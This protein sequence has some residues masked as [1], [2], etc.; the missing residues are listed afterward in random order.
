MKKTSILSKMTSA[1]V[2]WS[3]GLVCATTASAA[4]P[5]D[6]AKGL[7][8]TSA[9]PTGGATLTNFPVLVRLGTS[10]SG[11]SYD[12]FQLEGGGDLMFT[13][14][15]GT[16]LAHEVDTW[17]ANGTSLVWVKVPELTQGSKIHA[18]YGNGVDPGATASDAWNG[19]A[20]VW[21]LG[22]DNGTAYDATANNLNGTPSGSKAA[23]MVSYA[24]G[25]VGKARVNFADKS[26]LS[27]PNYNTLG[28]G[29]TFTISGWFLA[30]SVSGYPR[31]FSR[32]REYAANDGWEIEMSNSSKVKAS[33]RGAGGTSV[34]VNMPDITANWLHLA[35]VYNG[36]TLSCY[37][38]GALS[39][40]GTIGTATDNGYPL[41]FGC[42]SDGSESAFNGQYDE[43]RLV[44]GVATPIW[45]ATE[46]AVAANP[47]ALSYGVAADLD[48]TAPKFAT[49]T[50]VKNGDGT[51]SVSVSL[52]DGEGDLFVLYNDSVTNA[53]SNGYVQAP[54]SYTDTPAN[55][56]TNTCYAYAAFG[57][58]A[59]GTAVTKSGAGAFLTGE[60]SVEKTAD[61]DEYGLVAGSFI[62]SRPANDEA[63]L[64]DLAVAYTVSGT[65]IAGQN[66]V[67]DLSGTLVIPAGEAS[68]SLAVTPLIDASVSEDT[69]LVLT[70]SDGLYYLG[71]A[72]ATL[73]VKNLAAP[74]GYN[75][76]V[77]AAAGK[78]S[79]VQNWSEGRVPNSTENILLDGRFS[80]AAMEW[81]AGVNGLP[82]TVASWTQATDYTG[83]VTFPINYPTVVGATFTNFTVTGNAVLDGGTWTHPQSIYQTSG[84]AYSLE[85]MRANARYRLR[86]SVGGDMTIGSAATIN[87]TEK[88]Y[89]RYMT[90]SNLYGSHGGLGNG[91]TIQ[92]Y[93]DPKC[94][95]DIGYTHSPGTDSLGKTSS[96]GGAVYLTVGGTLTVNGTI[97]ADGSKNSIGGSAAGS[98]YLQAD[99]VA[100][101]GSVHANG[102][103]PASD[104]EAGAGGRVAVVSTTT[105]ADTLA[106]AATSGGA[107]YSGCGTVYTKDQ[108]GTH[109]T[110]RVANT[111]STQT[112]YN[113][114]TPV[115]D[116][117]DWTFDAVVVGSCGRVS[118]GADRTLTLPNGLASVSSSDTS[119]PYDG[120]LVNGGAIAAGTGDQ[121]MTGGWTL[122]INQPYT[123]PGNLSLES[124]A[125]LGIFRMLM[126]GTNN[127]LKADYTVDGNLTVDAN[128]SVDVSQIY[129]STAVNAVYPPA[130]HGGWSVYNN[131]SNT[132]GSVF[133][134]DTFGSSQGK[135]FYGSG[136]L[137]LT[138]GGALTVNGTLGA[139]GAVSDSTYAG[140]AAASGG[141][142]DITAG[143][144]CGS[145]SIGASGA[146]GRWDYAGGGA[147]GR[148]AVRLTGENADFADAPAINAQGQYGYA[149]NVG[150]SMI[151]SAGT[152]YMQTADQGEKGGTI[153][154]SNFDKAF[155]DFTTFIASGK[156]F[157]TTPIVAR[158]IGKDEAKDFND[159]SLIVTKTAIAEVSAPTLKMKSLNV[160]NGSRLEL[161][162][163]TLMVNAAVIGETKL[164]SGTYTASSAEVAGYVVDSVG[165]GSVVV[166][167]AGTVVVVR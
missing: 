149:F 13:D 39:V 21:H 114:R 116:E 74:A 68:A 87:A 53:L 94:P 7:E 103:K 163:N 115:T 130:T 33:A 56:V 77:A 17:N 47:G 142:L 101:S 55:L 102:V 59:N 112:G 43:I 143:S 167:G 118:V 141:S 35:L 29:G 91:A 71:T 11:F 82:D 139:S 140:N 75:T 1:L 151:A 6:F 24:N 92:P 152:V 165:G 117:G 20:G 57:T 45:V 54:Q 8:I 18:Y 65:A 145:G 162:G 69:T 121:T 85:T 95:T 158:G 90:G 146:A 14:D 28:L 51:F 111:L 15:N 46:Y 148:I 88:G 84:S 37:T 61:A 107:Y 128:S 9:V 81:D 105:I 67:D 79:T 52:T 16:P 120:I 108:N 40:S 50:I 26:Y 104:K 129:H 150:A 157:P 137:K 131:A 83:T 99:A 159:A 76:W 41:S 144:L 42:D 134:P 36:T 70:I 60:V 63:R 72:S 100:G 2:G 113:A 161:A 10:I 49:P 98:I 58:N 106:L 62:F 109:G 123:F 38:N 154:V 31:L 126:S 93:G 89:W 166:L 22:E 155:S 78:A 132:Y 5:T 30:N 127:T 44:D 153:L 19:Y 110:L 147:G 125:R 156:A 23:S 80:T 4:V 164:P 12:D 119:S 3:L 136:I 48:E 27:I 66:Y 34:T 97:A 32:K 86:V 135:G 122:Q 73:T 138:V 133:H 96:G 25:A 64:H 160:A 124:G